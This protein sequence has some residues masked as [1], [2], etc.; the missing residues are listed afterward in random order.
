MS[1]T[2]AQR[3]EEI[4]LE[5]VEAHPASRGALL[6]ERCGG[7][8]ALRA[9]V[10][11]LLG[12][13]EGIP[14]NFLDSRALRRLADQADTATLPPG[15]RLGRYTITG[16]VGAGGMGVVYRAEQDKPR[17]T[18]AIKVIRRLIGD[19]G[20]L[21][22]FE[23][24]AETLGR[25]HHPG[26]AQIFDAGAAD[27]GFGPQP[28]IAMELVSGKPLHEFARDAGLSIRERVALTAMICDAVEH[29]HQRGVIH[30][31]L[32]P[33]NILVED[34]AQGPRPKVL[35]FG[36]ARA[37]NADIQTSTLRTNVGQL[38]GTLAYMSP[39]QVAADPAEIDTRTDVF[40][41]GVIL[42]E[43]LAG[44][45]PLDLAGKPLPEAARIVRDEAPRPLASLNPALRGDLS[46]VVAKALEK[47]KAR[48]YRSAA[49][50]AD[51]LR[52]WLEG[53][54]VAAQ[55]DS[56][57]YVARKVMWRHRAWV[58]AAC[59]FILV[60]AAFAAYAAVESG[61]KGR[62]ARSEQAS[63]LA[64]EAARD[65]AEAHRERADRETEKFRRSLYIS[66]I[67]FAQAAYLNHD[68]ERLEALL[69]DCPSDLRSWE[70]DYLS[71]VTD[72]S[73]TTTLAS[74][75]TPYRLAAAP[76][77]GCAAMPDTDGTLRLWRPGRPAPLWS[78]P[79]Q[80]AVHALFSPDA[81]R[82][83][84]T[85]PGSI[86]FLDP[87][88]GQECERMSADGI[89]APLAFSPEGHA[90]VFEFSGPS[91]VLMDLRTGERL[92]LG[93]VNDLATCAAFSPDGRRVLIGDDA[94]G[95]H[96]FDTATAAPIASLEGHTRQVR[97]VAFSPDGRRFASGS[98]DETLRVWDA[99]SLHTI[100]TA[101]P[102]T[103]KVTALDWSPDGRLLATG[104]TDSTIR[105][106]DA[107]TGEPLN[108]LHGHR[109]TVLGLRFTADS[110]GLMSSARDGLV[111]SW[112]RLTSPRTPIIRAGLGSTSVAISPD[113]AML[114]ANGG[115][116]RVRRWSLPNRRRLEDLTTDA[117]GVFDVAFSPTGDL[118]AVSL[119]NGRLEF[120]DPVNATLLRRVEAHR[121]EAKRLSFSPDGSR[122]ASGSADGLRIFRVADGAELMFY[123]APGNL[124]V[125]N[126]AWFP[127]GASLLVGCGDGAIRRLDAA[128]G[129][130]LSVHR[131]HD[132]VVYSVAI[133]DGGRR[134]ASCSEDGTVRLW[135]LDAPPDSE[136]IV[137]A[138]HKAAA[139][140]IA[141]HPTGKRIAT[142]GFDNT[143]RLWDPE[144]GRQVLTLQGHVMSV[145]G[146]AFSPDGKVLASA[147]DDGSI[148][149]WGAER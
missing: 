20:T 140:W 92:L 76:S 134:A 147:S 79:P 56:A 122:L 101:R 31:D 82:L 91:A 43:L 89:V 117:Q 118:L 12:H 85:S 75:P 6:S 148:R 110:S 131:G 18:V 37:T 138:G 55:A 4:F 146:L 65:L 21:R 96:L 136:P 74:R 102:H 68:V 7:D 34:A 47:D 60:L 32:K 132:A 83:V 120:W 13:H 53:K 142:G 149:L 49:T 17:R 123:P 24:E 41:L 50:L 30:R 106:L 86:R 143:V 63:R 126:A 98:G 135:T 35:D 59:V 112:S 137:M 16:V 71:R 25:L 115:D 36:V 61:R 52:A 10:E 111:K 127:D 124:T 1:P 144:T 130:Q 93:P 33:A 15:T 62:L 64:A 107:D 80:T 129:D 113:G 42:Y 125:F 40:S 128:T 69:A 72:D 11:S 90:V 109:F 66:N 46:T 87:D 38:V 119:S 99:E 81:S 28:F 54:P 145:G 73:D 139:Y 51:D 23:A 77:A 94:G 5:L 29:A 103:N 19:A 39:E 133:L 26:I 100:Y 2:L 58:A 22:R 27:Y 116:G 48:R 44:R 97:T 78:T 8:I 108:T 104:S 3:A 114:A 84:A 95:L 14:D 9:E 141:V 67:G 88:S 121:G 45:P 105:V 70:W 57:W